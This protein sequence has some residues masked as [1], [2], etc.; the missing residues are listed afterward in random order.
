[1]PHAHPTPRTPLAADA[2]NRRIELLRSTAGADPRI[3]GVL[4]FATETRW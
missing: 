2:L 1:M 4:L 3:E